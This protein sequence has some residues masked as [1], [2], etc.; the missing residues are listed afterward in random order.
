MWLRIDAITYIL[1]VVISLVTM[2]GAQ[3]KINFCF[4]LGLKLQSISSFMSLVLIVWGWMI[5]P[6]SSRDKCAKDDADINPHT[7]MLLVLIV[8]ASCCSCIVCILLNSG[9]LGLSFSRSSSGDYTV[10]ASTG[11]TSPVRMR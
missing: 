2:A 11:P 5:L 3:A 10:P 8:Q 6:W 1:P 4:K 7:L 9:G